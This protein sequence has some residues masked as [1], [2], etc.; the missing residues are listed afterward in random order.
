MEAE[1]AETPPAQRQ[2]SIPLDGETPGHSRQARGPGRVPQ[3][4]PLNNRRPVGGGAS[5]PRDGSTSTSTGPQ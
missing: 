3:H 4:S 5:I 2:S 1:M